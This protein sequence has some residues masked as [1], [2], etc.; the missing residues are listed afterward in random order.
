MRSP[1][2]PDRRLVAL[3]VVALAA[4]VSHSQDPPAASEAAPDAGITASR[5][6]IVGPSGPREGD[7]P[8]LYFNVQGPES[9]GDG[10]FS[11]F[12]VLDFPRDAVMGAA[13]AG[14]PGVPG[15]SLVLT[16]SIPPFARNGRV[17]VWLAADSG[18]DEGQLRFAA[19][20]DGPL[21]EAGTSAF[22]CGTCDFVVGETGQE[23]RI[24]LS[25]PEERWR[26]ITEGPEEGTL[27]LFILPD[28]PGVA[29]TWFGTDQPR[30]ARHP[31]LVV[32]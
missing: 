16:Q 8:A 10:R 13:G 32:D 1:V 3:V 6:R 17:T 5:S 4:S 7:K 25:I 2:M 11:S 15:L 23:D 27:R 24:P 26:A 30:G 18:S 22:R 12:G 19:G 9:R 31:R 29:A 20:E 14:G 21:G 28:D